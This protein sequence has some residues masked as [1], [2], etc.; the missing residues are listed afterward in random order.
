MT[1]DFTL[2]ERPDILDKIRRC[3]DAICKI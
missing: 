3:G 2:H 1:N